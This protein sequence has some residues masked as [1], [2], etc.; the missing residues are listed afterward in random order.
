VRRRLLLTAVSALALFTSLP[1]LVAHATFPGQNGRV[2]YVTTA[3]DHRVIDTV[4]AQ[5]ADPQSLIDLGPGR[6]AI[7]PAWSSDGLKV[8]FAGQESPGGPFVIYVANADGT[9]VPPAL[10]DRRQTTLNMSDFQA[11]VVA[12]ITATTGIASAAG[13]LAWYGFNSAIGIPLGILALWDLRRRSAPVARVLAVTSI[14]LG[15]ASLVLV[16]IAVDNNDS[17]TLAAFVYW[18]ALAAVS[19]VAWF[20][21]RGI[22]LLGRRLV[23][24]HR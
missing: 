6:D 4:D 19:T 22:F 21:I 18:L 13:F 14:A 24:A 16:V 1:V 12:F 2:A 23:A 8:T 17:S 5:G 11:R 20:V 15:T 9:G 10:R 7:D 3:G